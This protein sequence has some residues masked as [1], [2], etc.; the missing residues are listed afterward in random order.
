M[1]NTKNLF[2]IKVEAIDNFGHALDLDI[3]VA[4]SIKTILIDRFKDIPMYQDLIIRFSADKPNKMQKLPFRVVDNGMN[5]ALVVEIYYPEFLNDMDDGKRIATLL[6]CVVI[7]QVKPKDRFNNAMEL[8]KMVKEALKSQDITLR[9][10]EKKNVFFAT[11]KLKEWA[12]SYKADLAV[13]MSQKLSDN[14]KAPKVSNDDAPKRTKLI[15]SATCVAYI[16]LEPNFRVPLDKVSVAQKMFG[17]CGECGNAFVSMNTY[18]E[19]SALRKQVKELI[20][21][22]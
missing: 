15:C 19:Q 8:S 12:K 1:S 6:T 13:I 14:W 21:A 10:V 18:K 2:D 7:A 4:S 16:E 22:S 9:K 3:K 17:S 5:N 20:E 11:S